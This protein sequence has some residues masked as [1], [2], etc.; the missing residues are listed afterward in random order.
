MRME[1][2]QEQV[3]TQSLTPQMIQFTRVLQ[4]GVQELRDY[5]E[6]SLQEN[7]VF[8][9]PEP[10]EEMLADQSFAKKL[11]WLEAGD[12]QDAYYQ[13]QDEEDSKKDPLSRMGCYLSDENDLSRFVLSQFIGTKL[14]PEVL[15]AVELLCDRLD[16]D[17]FLSE[18]PAELAASLGVSDAVIFRALTE[19]Q[20]ADPA[21]VGARNLTECLCLQ[22]ER[23]AGDHRLAR[24]IVQQYMEE[25]AHSRYGVISKKTGA[26][27]ALVREECA[28]IRSLNPRP[29][30]GFS[31][32]ENLSYITPDVLVLPGQDGK[33]EVEVNG[34]GL[35]K[36][37]I[38]HYYS[39]LL[40]ETPDEEVRSYLSEK[41]NQ[42][43]SIVESIQ[44]RQ[45]T[46]L[47]CAQ[48]I[49][50]A[51]EEFFQKGSGHLRPLEMQQVADAMGVH[52]STISRAVKDKYLQC[53]QGIYPMSWFF[54]REVGEGGAS[55]ETAKQLLRQLVEEETK[56]LSD[57]K[58]SEELTRRGCAISR[59]TVA[60][61]REELGIP[62]ASG[63]K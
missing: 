42:A 9:L 26:S 40:L 30:T 27:E 55:A 7:P 1:Y 13:G 49:V 25:L 61:Y 20:A 24:T 11:E 51:Q 19:L 18:D 16:D 46:L 15:Q 45:N 53:P 17:G 52:K 36:L 38:S 29:G 54:S 6:D 5:V 62:A 3:L 10:G 8:E 28:L 59:R 50:A 32:R 22:I 58:L 33:L 43:R 34:G 35:P 39:S 60:K 41:L 12:R 21:G 56:P 2:G 23:H 63:R 47:R 44:Q 4:M 31:R 37:N 57:Q 14:E 48:Q